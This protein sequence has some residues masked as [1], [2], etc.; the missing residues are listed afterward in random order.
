MDTLLLFTF[1]LDIQYFVHIVVI[2]LSKI[3]QFTNIM[4][5]ILTF[6]YIDQ[7]VPVSTPD[8]F[9]GFFNSGELFHDTLGLG[10]FVF[11][12]PSALCYTY[13]RRPLQLF[14]CSCK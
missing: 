11:Q 3:R 14:Q 7:E 10:V 9:V 1:L 5:D 2:D 4:Y 13:V 12:Y 8:C 6:L